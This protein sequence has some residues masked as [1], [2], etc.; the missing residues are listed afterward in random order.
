MDDRRSRSPAS[1]QQDW[2][3]SSEDESDRRDRETNA[4]KISHHNLGYYEGMGEIDQDMYLQQGFDQG[5]QE[6]FHLPSGSETRRGIMTALTWYAKKYPENF[7]KKF[8][9][10]QV[11]T[12]VKLKQ[13]MDQIAYRLPMD[14]AQHEV[15]KTTF[16][17]IMN[18]SDCGDVYQNIQV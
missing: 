12:L 14:E 3:S 5:Y 16:D 18:E 1:S 9:A 11:D 17:Q 13:D 2:A 6:G 8:G 15:V 4:L 7:Q 10:A